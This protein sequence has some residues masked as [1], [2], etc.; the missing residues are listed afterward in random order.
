MDY[1]S[2][3]NQFAS[4]NPGD[5]YMSPN[6]GGAQLPADTGDPIVEAQASGAGAEAP[7]PYGG[8][9]GDPFHTAIVASAQLAALAPPR[10]PRPRR[11]PAPPPTPFAG[12]SSFLGV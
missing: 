12:L 4:Q 11:V 6:A 8:L 7:A 3:L 9:T 5:A 10:Y 1:S 2:A